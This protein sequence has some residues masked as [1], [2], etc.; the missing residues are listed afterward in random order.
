MSSLRKILGEHIIGDHFIG[1][2]FFGT[3]LIFLP[4]HF[5]PEVTLSIRIW[6]RVEIIQA[7]SQNHGK[8]SYSR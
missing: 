4:L 3:I 2:F 1:V 5:L 8:A 7:D 6:G